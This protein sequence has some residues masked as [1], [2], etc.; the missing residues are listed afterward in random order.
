MSKW[1]IPTKWA[2]RRGLSTIFCWILQ[3]VDNV[4]IEAQFPNHANKKQGTE[5]VWKRIPNQLYQCSAIVKDGW[6]FFPHLLYSS[7]F[8][9]GGFNQPLGILVLLKGKTFTARPF[10]DTHDFTLSAFD[11][12]NMWKMVSHLA[13]VDT[14]DN[15]GEIGG[16]ISA[17]DWRDWRNSSVM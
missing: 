17:L 5:D 2:T 7:M 14:A 8:L 4:I 9:F 15:F 3:R 1:A 13:E 6:N 12:G 11:S 10:F 16:S